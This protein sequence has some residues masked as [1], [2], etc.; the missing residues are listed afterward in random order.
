MRFLWELFG[1]SFPQSFRRLCGVG[2]KSRQV[3]LAVCLVLVIVEDN[4]ISETAS[5]DAIKC[6]LLLI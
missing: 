4:V 5:V 2:W 3:I 1:S 6:F